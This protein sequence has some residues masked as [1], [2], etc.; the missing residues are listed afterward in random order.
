MPTPDR[1]PIPPPGPTAGSRGL[2]AAA[3]ALAIGVFA[4]YWPDASVEFVRLDDWQYVVDNPLVRQPTWAG[5]G[6]VFAEVGRPTTVDGYYQ[7]V[8]MASL[9]LDGLLSGGEPSPFVFRL[10]NVFYHAAAAVLLMLALR[11]VVGGVW[12]PLLVAALFAL[13][14]VQVESV[15]WISQRKTVLSGALAMAMLWCCLQH[16]R[17]SRAGW[18]LGAIACFTLAVLAKPTVIPLALLPPLLNRCLSG[19]PRPA[20]RWHLPF[21]AIAA[22]LGL[23]AWRSQAGSGAGLATPVA[24]SAGAIA[25]LMMQ[26]LGKYASNLVWPM[27]LSPYTPV[28][29][30]PPSMADAA[31]AIPAAG[32]LV[33]LTLAWLGRHRAA[34][35]TVGLLGALLL[36]APAL[37]VIRFDDTVVADRFLYLPLALLALPLAALARRVEQSSAQRALIARSALAGALIPLSVL[38]RA[39]QSVWHNSFALWTHIADICPNLPKAR[40]ELAVQLLNADQPGAALPHAQ[41]AVNL[42]PDHAGYVLILAG[43]QV[44]AGDPAE[45]ERT[46]RRALALGLGPQTAAGHATIAEARLRR[47]DAAGARATLRD[48]A[49]A[50]GADAYAM[51]Q[52]AEVAWRIADAP[53]LAV[54]LYDQALTKQPDSPAWEWNRGAALEKAGRDEEAL[55]AYEKVISAIQRSLAPVPK[56]FTEAWLAVSKRLH[57]R[58]MNA[59]RRPPTTAPS[60]AADSEI[61]PSGNPPDDEDIDDAP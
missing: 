22:A 46:A 21:V 15:A 16:G 44:R 40:Y 18:F 13:H 31:C 48:A 36:I 23:V 2:P 33:A 51:A 61:D 52:L 38:N 4:V 54:E 6:R 19:N 58:E 20:W 5:V 59:P 25:A 41:A 55:V 45:G 50:G 57:E 27:R 49:A 11:A 10:T 32:L 35:G 37:G 9:M 29:T 53:D 42:L 24:R 1:H 43:C 28:P 17:T 34:T 14:P 7:P 30:Q 26:S 12:I 3:L 39:Q 47:H 56:E 8:T 60:P